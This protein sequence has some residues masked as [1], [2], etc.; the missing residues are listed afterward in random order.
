MPGASLTGEVVASGTVVLT[1]S[2]VTGGAV[3]RGGGVVRGAGAVAIG[4]VGQGG[5]G[6]LV[7][8]PNMS[9]VQVASIARH[10]MGCRATLFITLAGWRSRCGSVFMAKVWL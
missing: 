1:T 7:H 2:S 5:R 3:P 6:V 10:A 9:A 4:V 8:A